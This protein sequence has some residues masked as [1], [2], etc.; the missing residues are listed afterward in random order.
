MYKKKR[1]GNEWHFGESL[2]RRSLFL[3]HDPTPINKENI[4]VQNNAIS[5]YTLI[6]ST[7]SLA[8]YFPLSL[9]D[10]ISQRH[11]VLSSESSK[12]IF[13]FFFNPCPK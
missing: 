12:V 7:L 10:Q 6:F 3:F 9:S 5:Y 8:R 2:K 13:Y 11:D 1:K 4:T